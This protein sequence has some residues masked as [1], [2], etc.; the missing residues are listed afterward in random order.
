MT[1]H[2][3][4]LRPGADLK[5]ELDALAGDQG[6]SAACV[7]S[8]IGSLSTAVIRFAGREEAEV[9]EGSLEILS[10]AGTLG[11]GG[12]HLHLVVGDA[13]GSVTG[14]HLKEGSVVRT[15]AEIVLAI[16]PEWNFT[17]SPDPETG[18]PELEVTPRRQR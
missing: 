12:S 10:L 14:G 3:L 7:L 18:Y 11:S 6:W 9:M 1:I 17:R 5:R 15:T 2:P 16:L 8:G 4:R 13:N